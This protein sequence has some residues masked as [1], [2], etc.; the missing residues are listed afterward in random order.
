MATSSLPPSRPFS[1]STAAMRPVDL[2]NSSTASPGEISATARRS[3]PPHGT[4]DP[5]PAL[6]PVYLIADAADATFMF[7]AQAAATHPAVPA[8]PYSALEADENEE[9]PHPHRRTRASLIHM[10]PNPPS[11]HVL[12]SSF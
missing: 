3:H 7:P 1:F 10:W 5:S 11:W 8:G 12:G 2:L 4:R 9:Q 6:R